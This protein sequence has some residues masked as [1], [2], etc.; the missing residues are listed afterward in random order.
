MF[1]IS[2]SI[3]L[4]Y[5]SACLCAVLMFDCSGI[6]SSLAFSLLSPTSFYA[7]GTLSPTP[8]PIALYD[9]SVDEAVM[10]L[11]LGDTERR[12]AGGAVTQVLTF[13]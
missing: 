5:R 4:F 8:S 12:R 1:I 7:A 2:V 13:F 10:Y 6:I 3:F 9:A 11:G